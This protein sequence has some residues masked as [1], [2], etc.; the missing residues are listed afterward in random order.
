MSD[1]LGDSWYET[2]FD[3]EAPS[4][5]HDETN[6]NNP[7]ALERFDLS[8]LDSI[9]RVPKDPR[10]V[11]LERALR[12]FIELGPQRP[13]IQVVDVGGDTR[14]VLGTWKGLTAKDEQA[15]VHCAPGTCR[16]VRDAEERYLELDLR[17]DTDGGEFRVWLLRFSDGLPVRYWCA[18][19]GRNRAVAHYVVDHSGP[20]QV[21]QAKYTAIRARWNPG[22]LQPT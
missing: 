20:T 19:D 15:T 5:P 9:P 4:G 11:V 12:E 3:D 10:L 2:G 14:L 6:E 13:F 18:V 7:P 16:T 21:S 17:E 1:S 8:F 22:T